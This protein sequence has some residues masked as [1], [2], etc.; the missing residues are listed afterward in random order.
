MSVFEKGSVLVALAALGLVPLA[1]ADVSGVERVRLVDPT[2]ITLRG[3]NFQPLE[4]VTISLSLGATDVL[5][6]V[7]A[8]SL[9]QFVTVF[10]K[11]RYDRCNG[12]LGVKAVGSLG[13]SAAW[14]VVPLDCPDGGA[15]S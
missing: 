1:T 8:G 10:P 2:P 13:S 14:K 6:V 3:V 12:A 15:D 9:G 7:R 5:R 4:R 11:L